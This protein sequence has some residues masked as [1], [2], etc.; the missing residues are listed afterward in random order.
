MQ[1]LQNQ[2]I[3]HLC[4]LLALFILATSCALVSTYSH[5]EQDAV[6]MQAESLIRK[7]DYKAAYLLLEPLEDARAGE[8]N[9]D[10]LFGIAGVES[11]N[12]TRG[13]FALERVLAL[14]PNNKDARTEMA[15]AHFLLG[16]RQASKAEFNNVLAL[17]PDEQ[18]KKTIDNLL[19]AIQKIEG[20]TTTF[21]AYAEF[22]LGADSN[23]SSAPNINAI[24]V[25]LFGGVAELGQDGREQSSNFMQLATGLSFRQPV[26]DDFAYFG[27][28]NLAHRGNETTSTFNTSN[29]DV[30]LGLQYKVDENNFS[31]ALQNNNFYLDSSSFRHAYGATAQ[32]LYNIDSFNQAGVFAQY[33]KISY[34]GNSIRNAQRSI[35]GVNVGHVFQN[36][37]SPVVFAS[38]YGGREDADDSSVNF[39]SQNIVGVRLGGQLNIGARLQL[40]TSLGIEK[41]KNDENDISFLT[42]RKDNQYDATLG[43]R[44]AF[45]RDWSI[46]P[47]YSYT[48][49]DSNIDLN[50][51]ERQI[52]SISIRKDFNW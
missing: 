13:A 51:F 7:A 24:S 2:F 22:G 49:N 11:G 12:V 8:I 30:N 28:V 5:A 41:R 52:L 16:E 6:L 47:Q 31:F 37:F 35:A 40:T 9:Y 17:N 3:R 26:N 25:P 48:K 42:K 20:T 18:T 33:S 29:V 14:D 36:D 38:V 50:T 1:G 15:K 32:W 4:Q 45:A 44:Y 46:R 21:G 34:A 43:L 19:T 10:F 23:I 27:A 39:L